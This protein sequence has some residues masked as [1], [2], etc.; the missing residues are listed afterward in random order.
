MK[1]CIF[2]LPAVWFALGLCRG[3]TLVLSTTGAVCF[4]GFDVVNV[5]DKEGARLHSNSNGG[6]TNDSIGGADSF[7]KKI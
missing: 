1:F 4:C 7:C 5:V 2:Y 3:A 6:T